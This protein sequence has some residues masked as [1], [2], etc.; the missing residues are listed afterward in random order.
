MDDELMKKAVVY[1][2]SREAALK[3]SG[4]VILSRAEI[5]SELGDVVNGTKPALSERTSVFKSLGMG[6]QDAVSAKLV[7]DHWKARP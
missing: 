1:V 5:F 3:E 2:D 7:F 6:I 4:D